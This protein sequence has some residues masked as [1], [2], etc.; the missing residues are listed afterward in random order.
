[1]HQPGAPQSVA[2]PNTLDL[3]N[4]EPNPA[5]TQLVQT[6]DRP[7]VASN[8][9]GIESLKTSDT[10]HGLDLPQLPMVTTTFTPSEIDF[11]HTTP[12]PNS[13]RS[14]HVHPHVGAPLPTSPLHHGM[15]LHPNSTPPPNPLANVTGEPLWME[16]KQTLNYFRSTFKLGDLSNVIGHWYELEGL[17]GFQEVV[18][19]CGWLVLHYAHDI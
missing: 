16:K 7:D 12:I 13:T 4:N 5:P 17:L 14:S 1:M 2:T 19:I 9:F 18:S 8:Q 3:I 15:A 10:T 11:G 6:S